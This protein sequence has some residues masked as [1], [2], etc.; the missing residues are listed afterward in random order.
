MGIDIMKISNVHI[1]EKPYIPNYCR[2]EVEFADYREKKKVLGWLDYE[3]VEYETYPQE[4][5][6]GAG[7]DFR[8]FMRT[9]DLNRFRMMWG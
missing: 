3:E 9:E 2:A 1:F 8:I 7:L 6:V 4:V 5:R